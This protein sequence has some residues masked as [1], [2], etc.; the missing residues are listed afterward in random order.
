MQIWKGQTGGEDGYVS[1]G[2]LLS[3]FCSRVLEELTR[4]SPPALYPPPA[5]LRNAQRRQCWSLLM[6][7][8]AGFS[9]PV[10][11]CMSVGSDRHSILYTVHQHL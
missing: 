9:V 4:S 7:A 6:K 10:C 5:S 1:A 2:G 8:E 11:V 3:L